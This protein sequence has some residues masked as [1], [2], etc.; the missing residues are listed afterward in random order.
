MK[1]LKSFNIYLFIVWWGWGEWGGDV[2]QGWRSKDHLQKSL[3]PS[4]VRGLCYQAW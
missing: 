1:F 2:A 4:T 3:L